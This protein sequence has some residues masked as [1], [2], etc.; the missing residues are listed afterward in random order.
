MTVECLHPTALVSYKLDYLICFIT[1]TKVIIAVVSSITLVTKVITS[2]I[3]SSFF[4]R[5]NYIISFD[6]KMSTIF[7]QKIIIYFNFFLMR[8][9]TDLYLLGGGV[10]KIST[11][12]QSVQRVGSLLCMA[13]TFLLGGINI[14][15]LIL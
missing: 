5:I 6:E 4:I 10:G 2:S 9:I 3:G 13:I 15:F 14:I 12:F 11:G 7:L 1:T 8:I